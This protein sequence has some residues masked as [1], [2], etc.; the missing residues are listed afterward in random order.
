ML[1]TNWLPGWKLQ[2]LDAQDL[3]APYKKEG[4]FMV[5]ACKIL[6]D[7]GVMPKVPGRK[8]RAGN[9]VIRDRFPN[10]HGF[11]AT[12]SE[13]DKERMGIKDLTFVT[14]VYWKE[15]IVYS[16]Q[17]GNLGLD[18]TILAPTTESLL[19]GQVFLANPELT[20]SIHFH[21]QL[22]EG[23]FHPQRLIKVRYPAVK[24]SDW[25]HL[26]NLTE[27]GYREIGLLGHTNIN[28]DELDAAF[29][30]GRD[31]EETLWRAVR[32]VK[33]SSEAGG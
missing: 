22:A 30:F 19:A 25:R 10:S 17:D 14:R 13:T 32:L 12:G 18:E 8:G 23:L 4:D 20:V 1:I 28:K 24:E 33:Q 21:K 3:F 31:P 2:A 9:I 5:R 27:K 11:L 7:L 26:R 29:V 6:S 15:K 16:F